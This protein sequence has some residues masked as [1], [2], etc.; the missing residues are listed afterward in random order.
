[1]RSLG[2]CFIWVLDWQQVLPSADKDTRIAAVL[3]LSGKVT[4][5]QYVCMLTRGGQMKK[6]PT[7]DFADDKAPSRKGKVAIKVAVRRAPAR[8]TGR[9]ACERAI[10]QPVTHEHQR[11]TRTR[12]PGSWQE[13]KPH[14]FQCRTGQQ[15]PH[16][17]A[18]SLHMQAVASECQATL[19]TPQC[20]RQTASGSQGGAEPGA[21]R[22]PR[23]QE[24]DELV[25]VGACTAADSVLLA[26]SDGL[27][28][29]FRTDDTQ[30]RPA[31]LPA[32]WSGTCKSA[33]CSAP[34]LCLLP[35]QGH[36]SVFLQCP[37]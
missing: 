7:A 24:G 22:S 27:V 11:P 37:G 9:H 29:R 16:D 25:W 33:G 10:G 36:A 2:L 30:V 26:A 17:H 1:M 12:D 18:S 8:L 21:L 31:G 34:S 4:G 23:A 20:P 13:V 15:R 5:D 32:A 3:P 28:T 14:G 35:T 6:T 19:R